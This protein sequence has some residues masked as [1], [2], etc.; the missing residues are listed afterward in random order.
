MATLPYPKPTSSGVSQRMRQNR[1]RDTRPEMALRRE[2]HRNGLRFRVDMPIRLPG[3]IVRPDIVF[4][5]ARLAVFVDGCFWH[6][7][8]AHGNIPRA[9][10]NYWRPKLERNVSRDRIVDRALSAEG[11]NVIRAWEH[12]A[13]RD[14]ANRVQAALTG[15]AFGAN[16]DGASRR[17]RA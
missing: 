17:C 4:T 1:R 7:C 11:W 10:G 13:A 14:A 12:E 3:R 15:D 2:L 5:R 6:C 16:A 8:P 9:N